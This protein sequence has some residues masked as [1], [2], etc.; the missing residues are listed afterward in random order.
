MHTL[1]VT[2]LLEAVQ[3]D[4]RNAMYFYHLGVAQAKSGDDAKARKALNRALELQ[5]D[6]PRADDARS[7]LKTLVY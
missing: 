7:I 2:N 5:P 1:A 4:S 6:F 3:F